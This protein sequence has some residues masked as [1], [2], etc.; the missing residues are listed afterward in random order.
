MTNND[1]KISGV[2]FPSPLYGITLTIADFVG[3]MVFT[4]LCQ[5]LRSK[6]IGII[7]TTQIFL[8]CF[9]RPRES[10]RYPPL[11]SNTASC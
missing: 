11:S 2:N 7:C 5:T 6:L 4:I 8:G 3:C 1:Q 10:K 9:Q